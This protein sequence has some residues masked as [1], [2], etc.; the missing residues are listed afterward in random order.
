MDGKKKR[1]ALKEKR[2]MF[3]ELRTLVCLVYI[4][5][6]IGIGYIA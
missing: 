2:C 3:L 4:S 6:V 5:G 1:L